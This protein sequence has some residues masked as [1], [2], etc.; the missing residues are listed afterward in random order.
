MLL[1]ACASPHHPHRPSTRKTNIYIYWLF[2]GFQRLQS[3]RKRTRVS[4]ATKSGVVYFWC[5]ELLGLFFPWRKSSRSIWCSRSTQ[6]IF[7]TA[8][9]G[10]NLCVRWCLGN[11][12]L[13]QF[14]A[15]FSKQQRSRKRCQD[16]LLLALNLWPGIR[17][18]NIRLHRISGNSSENYWTSN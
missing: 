7:S 8:T 10:K 9:I 13:G 5:C 16:K 3:S 18:H 14:G 2:L 17:L 12:R 1:K 15:P 4:L 6:I 11:R